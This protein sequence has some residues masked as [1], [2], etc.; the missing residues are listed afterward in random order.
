MKCPDLEFG[1]I[2]F[3]DRI[4]HVVV[5]CVL[6]DAGSVAKDISEDDVAG[7]PHVILK[8]G[9]RGGTCCVSTCGRAVTNFLLDLSLYFFIFPFNKNAQSK[10]EGK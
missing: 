8:A 10:L 7:F 3:A 6:N 9:A 2:Q 1:V 4:L 5:V